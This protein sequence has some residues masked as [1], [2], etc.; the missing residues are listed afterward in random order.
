M[1]RFGTT[2]GISWSGARLMTKLILKPDIYPCSFLIWGGTKDYMGFVDAMVKE[3]AYLKEIEEQ[4]GNLKTCENTAGF[5]LDLGIVQGIFVKEALK[6][7]TVDTYAHEVYHAV[8]GAVEYLGLEGQ[9]A[10]AYLMD[11]LIREISKSKVK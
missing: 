10:G 6:W 9:E 2:L 1:V 5:R 4:V 3:G 7:S 8:V 11:Y